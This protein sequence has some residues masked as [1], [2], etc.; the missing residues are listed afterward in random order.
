MASPALA[1]VRPKRCSCCGDAKPLASFGRN[2]QAKD[3]LHY[4][5]K[6]CAAKRQREWARANPEIV[7]RMRDDY[8]Q[9]VYAQNAERDPYE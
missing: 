7:K 5:C 9:R 6:D 2:R 1:M 8:L 3:G 4:Y